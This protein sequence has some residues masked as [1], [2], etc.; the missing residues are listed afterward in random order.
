MFEEHGHG[1]AHDRDNN[2][3]A[4]VVHVL[5]DA[6]VSVLVIVELILARVF[7]WVWMDPVAGLVG[8]VVIAS[9]SYGLIRDTGS[10]LLDMTPDRRLADR[11]RH[12]VEGAGDRVS[13]L[14]LWRAIIPFANALQRS[15]FRSRM[16]IIRWAAEV[17]FINFDPGYCAQVSLTAWT[18][19][20]AVRLLPTSERSSEAALMPDQ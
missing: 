12:A 16:K 7:G 9:W 20:N 2:M 8:A 6:A 10:I 18:A 19:S 14:H 15:R 13:D 1:G 3:R 5:A 17:A 4:A 11:I